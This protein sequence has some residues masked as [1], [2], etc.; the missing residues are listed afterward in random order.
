MQNKVLF[1]EIFFAIFYW[2]NRVRANNTQTLFS[3]VNPN[4]Q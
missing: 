2:N 3:S 4:Y 1:R